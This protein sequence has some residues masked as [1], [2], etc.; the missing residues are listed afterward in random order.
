MRILHSIFTNITSCYFEFYGVLLRV[1]HIFTAGSEYAPSSAMFQHSQG[2]RF[3]KKLIFK[4]W[5]W[6]E[7]P[8]RRGWY[9]YSLL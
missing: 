1:L 4:I 2:I 9:N 8:D 6:S 5:V 7:Y 3:P